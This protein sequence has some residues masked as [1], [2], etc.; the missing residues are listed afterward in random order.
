M[1]CN[2]MYFFGFDAR[3][4]IWFMA[5]FAILPNGALPLLR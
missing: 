5:V 2:E 4:D 1:R 3:A